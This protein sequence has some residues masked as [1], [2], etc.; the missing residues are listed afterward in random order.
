MKITIFYSTEFFG[1][2]S[3]IEARLID[4]GRIAYAQYKNAPYVDFIPK[5]KRKASRYL[6]AYKPYLLILEGHSLG[7]EPG[8]MFGDGEKRDGVT[9]K[10][11]KYQAFDDRHLTDFDAIVDPLIDSG[12]VKVIAD[13]R[14]VK[15][16]H[17][18]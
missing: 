3:K 9:V 15:V 6:K 14:N 10:K 2:V 1:S 18:F 7:I 11:S 13:Y 17:K 12:R 16:D 5:G 4:H 8:D